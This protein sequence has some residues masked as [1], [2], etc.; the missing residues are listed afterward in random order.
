[1][2]FLKILQILKRDKIIKINISPLKIQHIKNKSNK[3]KFFTRE[4]CKKLNYQI[5][6]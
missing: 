4:V 6:K 3:I 1:M 2:N 5:N